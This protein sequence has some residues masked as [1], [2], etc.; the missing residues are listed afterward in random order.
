LFK[1]KGEEDEL[2]CYGYRR[3]IFKSIFSH[4]IS[5]LLAGFPYLVGYWKP[6]W[7]IKWF[8]SKCPLFLADTVLLEDTSTEEQKVAKV[9][10]IDVADNFVQRYV[11]KSDLLPED[12]MS[13]SSSDSSD[14]DRLWMP[15][16]YTFRFFIHHHCKVR[17]NA[18]RC[19][20]F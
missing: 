6:E 4:I 5:I 13:S 14:R 12:Y 20:N 11:H 17:N 3:D 18:S 16:K 2:L 19:F 8:R 9:T 1:L 15:T 10:V 7:R